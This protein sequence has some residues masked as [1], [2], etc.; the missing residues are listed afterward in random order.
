MPDDKYEAKHEPNAQVLVGDV[1]SFD[2]NETIKGAEQILIIQ[3]QHK[4]TKMSALNYIEKR[5][6]SVGKTQK[7][8]LFNSKID[9]SNKYLVSCEIRRNDVSP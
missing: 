1:A 4:K 8:A 5:Y 3:N 2:L 7:P 9:A 6:T